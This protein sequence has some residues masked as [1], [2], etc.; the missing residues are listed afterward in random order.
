[1][2]KNSF[3]P[4]SVYNKDYYDHYGSTAGVPY[5][6]DQPVWQK[7]FHTFAK[8]LIER[9]KPRTMLDV[10]C[11]KGFL[12]EQ[13]RDQGVEAF[14]VDVSPYAISQVREDIRPHCRVAKGTETLPGQ[15]DLI[16][17]V[18]VAEHVPEAEAR[19]MIEEMCRHTD[20]VIFSSTDDGFDEPTHINIH[21]KEY[22]VE[23]F[24]QQGFSRDLNFQPEFVTGQAMRFLRNTKTTLQ[25]GVFSHEP[26]NCAVALL[27]L[28]G[29]IRYLE[30]QNRMK[31][32]W[33]TARDPQIDIEKVLGCDIFTLHR[34]FCDHHF[35]PQIVA[36]ARELGKPIVFEL[37]DLLINVPK[38]NPNHKYCASITPD[39]LAMLREADFIT[40]TTEP[41]RRY[42]EEAE[43]QAKG[44][45]FVLPNFINL[46]IW[47]GAKPPPEKPEDPFVVGW[48]GT[49][50]HDEDLA[51][52]KP[53]IVEIARKYAGKVVFK[54]WGYL[55]EDLKDIPGV[56]LMRGSQPDLRLHARD[57]VNSRIDLAIAPLLDHPFNHAKSDLKWLEYSICYIPGI[58][59]TISPYTLAVEHGRTGWLVD[60]KPEL[61]LE[62][63]ERFINDHE[64]RRTIA[65][66][67][68]DEV[69]QKRCV[70]T[71]AEQWDTL[72]HSFYVSGPKPKTD[73]T[74]A[75]S[76]P[77]TRA[78]AYLMQYSANAFANKGDNVQALKTAELAIATCMP[79]DSSEGKLVGDVLK[80]YRNALLK[81][82][83]T[84]ELTA[85]LGAA[86]SL[87]D[88]GHQEAAVALYRQTLKLALQS[89]NPHTVLHVILNVAKAFQALDP[90]GGRQVLDIGAQLAKSINFQPG[91]QAIEQLRKEY[92]QK[93]PV[94][95][96]VKTTVPPVKSTKPN[97]FNNGV[98]P[99]VS[100][101]I[102]VFNNC[103]LTQAC[104][105]SLA[106]TPA[107]VPHEIIVVDNASTDGTAAYLKSLEKNGSLRVITNPSNQGFAQACNQGA[108]SA[109]G[110]LLL[111]LNN[112]TRVTEGWLKAL[113]KTAEKSNVGV[114]GA[115]LLYANGTIQHAG[116]EF[117][118]GV[119][120]HP[121][122]HAPADLPA[123]NKSRDLDMATGACLLTPRTLFLSLGGF[124]ETYRN[125]VEDVDYCLRVRSLGKKV[126]Y[127]PQS[128]VYHLEGQSAGRF[129]HVNENLKIFFDRWKGS[130]DQNFRFITPS[131]PKTIAASQSILLNSVAVSWEGS[132]LDYG[133]LSHVNRELVT[134]LKG[135]PHLKIQCV[136]SGGPSSAGAE[137][138]R[139]EFHISAQPVLN[140]AVTVRHAWPPNWRR[141]A[142]GKLAVIQPWEFG[143]LPQ[144]WV[145]RAREVDE[146]WVPSNYVRDVYISSGVP[147]QKVV[148]VPNGV[149]TEKFN[150]QAASMK[151]ATQKKFRFLFV[152]G[153]IGRKGPDLLL[154]AYLK[155][156]TDKDDVCL[157]IKDFGGKS[158]YAGQTFEAQIRAAQ[159]VPHAP[160]ILYL[161]DE[162]PSNSLPGLYTACNCLVLPYR[163]EG[164]GLPVLEAMA[165]GLPVI[166]TA[167]G[168]TDDFV[169]DEF[170]WRIPAV[171]K[172]FGHEVSGMKLAGDGWL[173][174]PDLA[175]LGE[176]MREAYAHQ[177]K[178]RERGQLAG[179]YAHEN[180][181]WEKSVSLVAERIQ[182]LAIGQNSRPAV[183]AKP[184][185]Y[186]LPPV[187]QV[188]QLNEARELFGQKKFEAAWNSTL[189]TIA[190]R[191]FH[192]EGSLLLAEIA[193]AAGDSNAARQC[194]Q[195]ARD[196]APGFTPAKQFLNK[197]LKGNAKFE[198]LKLPNEID[199]QK[200][201]TNNL[202]VC[203]I[204]KNEE[205]FLSQ[206]LKS[207]R[208]IAQQIIV[209]DTGSTD[210]TIAIAKEFGAE[211]HAH[212]WNNDF[213]AAR[214]AALEHAIGDWILV[215]DADEELPV[216]QHAQLLAD[217][218][219]STVIA[220]R[221]PLVN[222]GLE[223]EGRSFVPRLFRNVPGAHYVG[224][225]H[226]Q[227][228]NSL[229]PLS[230][231][232][233]LKVE[234]G[235]AEILHHGYNKE[236]VRDRN[237][238]ERNLK[239]LRLAHE[240]NPTDVNLTMN[241]GLELVR[242]E[243]LADGIAKYREAFQLMSE[244]P[245]GSVAPEL[246]EVLLTQFTSQLYKI[247]EHGEVVQ[248]LTSPLAKASGLTASLH[249]ALGLSQ[250][251]LRNYHEAA[252]QM[253]QCLAQRNQPAL[254]PI[255]TDI[256]TSMPN[257]CFALALAKI[258][259]AVGAEKAFEAALKENGLT[260]SVKADYAKFLAVT[261]RPVEALQK[262]H[263]LVATNCTNSALWRIGG[264]I[265]LSRP[266]LLDF[267][268][269]WTGE[270]M[271]YVA[272]DPA[273]A[274][275]RAETLMLSGDIV[276]ASDLWEKIYNGRQE[277]RSLAALILCET[278]ES[279]TTHA[280]E[281]GQEET[282]T[283]REFIG[284]YQRLITMRSKAA[285]GRLNEQMDKLSRALP[286]AAKKIEAAL[287]ESQ[288]REAVA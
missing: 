17:C 124:D 277:P 280:P 251:E 57:V 267:A 261:N 192:P 231:S 276:A 28:A 146:F 244:M 151:L 255:N 203:L 35:S 268:G 184:V 271:R 79:P 232:W 248:I 201:K 21:P 215:L 265:A 241:L 52:I 90:D 254:S 240:E 74:A 233:G 177:D 262:M 150:P 200:S 238:I 252:E 16:T 76:T 39:V 5:D 29:T 26:P 191:P 84:A 70:N 246:R 24:K 182:K 194:A 66:Q 259:D 167:G 97:S 228:F 217:M 176:K 96:P 19:I 242:S 44:K 134:A 81:L 89:K 148:V 103:A 116:I 154:Q 83:E 56:K 211:V 285:L 82:K 181:S 230:K 207:V 104:L 92:S 102:P 112:D 139:S 247:R 234:M 158:V 23:L 209:V 120:D 61:W 160:E 186:K 68:H 258:N 204:V 37:D 136:N 105:E 222:S 4:A 101:I 50:T 67:A 22:W 170:A 58:Y 41:L 270:A 53:A 9:Y 193:A 121:H 141:P 38:T 18:E 216:A 263:E 54:F 129:N 196:F 91:Q 286:T 123:A 47:D 168:S 147:E 30:Q 13:L 64:L 269:K 257:H 227:V 171:K 163:G 130:F 73:Q 145:D 172:I 266:E 137:K 86:K 109:K 225:I 142:T 132:F 190:K 173:L 115:K 202:S 140:A 100:I 110:S 15:Y 98:S 188:G 218:K 32:Q 164:F 111:F 212:T 11:A 60:N 80:H 166:V 260:E 157:V 1:M 126:I 236:M 85:S 36:T 138:I 223:S 143:S 185:T 155:N 107:N 99:V 175:A 174:E 159:S 59:S 77:R 180:C 162:L 71:G 165:C 20:Q 288:K 205:K 8:T 219:S 12:V 75:A 183:S 152:G 125:G 43:S 274:A 281:E 42:L 178:S 135:S 256:L 253:R 113:V 69:R 131:N 49:A 94:A 55:P 127:E 48:F 284:W 114:V 27:R 108:Q 237:K 235:T 250:F 88:A 198:W 245:S 153:T 93:I 264:E 118:N 279:Q 122:R 189:A 34:E 31:L 283:S 179:K 62:A 87:A 3:D 133:S 282:A 95:K 169:R 119:P 199:N 63:M 65:I 214:N 128:V 272:N 249:L 195:T 6:R 46:D 156:F 45:V 40:V 208:D 275:Q 273:V 106:R 33:T 210:R 229:L 187:A 78:T 10:G 2:N 51:I 161:N 224:R 206:C 220:Y 72:Y 117:I 226:E 221:L 144:E 25:V 287:A 278:I 213:S 239:L 197:S 14:G 243:N 149:D 7:H